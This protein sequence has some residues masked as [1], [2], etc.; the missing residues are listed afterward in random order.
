MSEM[1]RT[2]TDQTFHREVL[3][4][5]GPVLVDYW[6]QW[7]GP[8]RMLGPVIEESARQ[9]ADRL[10][11]AK[12]NVDENPVTP[13]RYQVRGIPTLMLFRDGQPV[14]THVGS[15]SRGQLQAFL[16]EHT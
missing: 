14:A 5:R 2:V 4:A 12:L 3:E 15:L 1:T 9:Y 6:A 10:I 16:D 13:S 7:C 11:V 8:C